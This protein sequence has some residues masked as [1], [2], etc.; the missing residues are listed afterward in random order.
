MRATR[1]ARIIQ[2]RKRSAREVQGVTSARV[3]RQDRRR[4]V[5]IVKMLLS[6][7]VFVSRTPLN[8]TTECPQP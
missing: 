7:L 4:G 5:I 1:P 6:K 3:A 2:M 8:G